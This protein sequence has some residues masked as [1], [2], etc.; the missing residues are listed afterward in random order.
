MK[1]TT[2][3]TTA[4]VA[5]VFMFGGM[6]SAFADQPRTCNTMFDAVDMAYLDNF[7]KTVKTEAQAA[8][9][10]EKT[11]TLKKSTMFNDSDMEF[12]QNMDNNDKAVAKSAPKAEKKYSLKKSTLF[13]DSDMEFF[14]NFDLGQK[15]RSTFFAKN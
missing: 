7:G 2:I 13:N 8:P 10:A 3:F 12:F 5:V 4:I 14:Q 6:S 15:L 9:K 11:Y 1:K